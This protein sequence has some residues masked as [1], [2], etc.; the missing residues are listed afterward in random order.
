MVSPAP[1]TGFADRH[2]SPF[3]S[4]FRKLPLRKLLGIRTLRATEVHSAKCPPER[5]AQHQRGP[6]D[7]NPFGDALEAV[8][9]DAAQ[10]AARQQRLQVARRC[11]PLAA[12]VLS[13]EA[14]EALSLGCHSALYAGW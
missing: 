7:A 8:R 12:T 2:P 13:M 5:A 10:V 9:G 11:S 3:F 14:E 1:V 6:M 4:L